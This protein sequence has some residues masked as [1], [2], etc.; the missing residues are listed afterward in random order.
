MCVSFSVSNGFQL[1]SAITL[2]WRTITKPCIAPRSPAS[3]VFSQPSM[4]FRIA[5]LGTPCDSGVAG[6]MAARRTPADKMAG[7]AQTSGVIVFFPFQ[8]SRMLT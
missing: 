5:S 7:M 4:N 3:N 8:M 2:P 1:P 6:S